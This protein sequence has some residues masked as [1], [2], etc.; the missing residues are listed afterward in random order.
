MRVYRGIE[1]F[2]VLD[3]V[4]IVDIDITPAPCLESKGQVFKSVLPLTTHVT[5]LR[6]LSRLKNSDP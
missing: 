6:E 3:L 4:G 1:M 5:N 2:T